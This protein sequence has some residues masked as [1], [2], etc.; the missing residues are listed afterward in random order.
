[1]KVTEEQYGNELRLKANAVETK[2]DLMALLDEVMAEDHD[3]GTIITAMGIMATAICRVIDKSPQ[4]GISG[5]QA[6]CVPWAFH[7]EFCDRGKFKPYQLIDWSEMLYPQYEVNFTRKTISE[8]TFKWLQKQA[9]QQLRNT[10]MMHPHVRE[11]MQKIVA[12]EVPFGYSLEEEEC[13][14][15]NHER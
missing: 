13:N 1:M 15:P 3:Y 11:H 12:G 7:Q 9:A 14:T 2:E 4:G 8:G 6:S 10:R 5:F